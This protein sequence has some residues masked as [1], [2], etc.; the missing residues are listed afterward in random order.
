MYVLFGLKQLFH[1]GGLVPP[2]AS[3]LRPRACGH[4]LQQTKGLCWTKGHCGDKPCTSVIGGLFFGGLFRAV[5]VFGGLF[6]ATGRP[7]VIAAGPCAS[8]WRATRR[9]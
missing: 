4:E 1:L 3:S 2:V 5:A 7:G 9:V 8:F 6:R